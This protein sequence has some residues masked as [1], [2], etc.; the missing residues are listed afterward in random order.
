METYN[1]TATC[2][3]PYSKRCEDKTPMNLPKW[4]SLPADASPSL[5]KKLCPKPWRYQ[6]SEEMGNLEQIS[7][8]ASYGG[9]GYVADLGYDIQT[10]RRV[11]EDL[12]K[13]SWI[14]VRS[15]AAIVEF[16]IFNINTN[17][18][19][20][21]NYF[22]EFLPTGGVFSHVK[23]EILQLYGTE[24]SFA[25]LV[26]LFRLL[27]IVM[28]IVYLV[29][30][31]VKLFRQK[32]SYFRNI[33][34]WLS[35][36]LII[37]SVT[38][39]V[40][41]IVG[42]QTT[43][44]IIKE[45][46]KNIY[47]TASFHQ[48][49]HL[50]DIETVVLAVVIF[51][52]TVKLLSLLRFSK[53]IIFLS[54]TVRFAG[55]CL[56]SFSIIFIIIFL[57]FATCGM[58]AFGNTVDSY[59]SF[60]RVCVSQFEFLLGKAVPNFDMAKVDPFLAFLFSSLYICSMTIFFLNV[61]I[62][63]L[64]AALVEVKDNL[65]AVADKLDLA[66]FIVA[67]VTQGL[68]NMFRKRQ[69]NMHK[70][71]LYCENM[72][73]ED[74]CTY[75]ENCLGEIDRKVSI[76]AQ[77]ALSED[78]VRLMKA[79]LGVSSSIRKSVSS[80]APNKKDFYSMKVKPETSM[81]AMDDVA[82]VE[83]P[84]IYDEIDDG[85]PLE[86]PLSV[87]EIDYDAPLEESLNDDDLSCSYNFDNENTLDDISNPLYSMVVLTAMKKTDT[88]YVMENTQTTS[89]EVTMGRERVSRIVKS[90]ESGLGNKELFSEFEQN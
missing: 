26:L 66:D 79:R 45:L 19:V 87:E 46:Q 83:E 31:A 6:R 68:V 49:I 61:F 38:A 14:D 41:H 50:L 36:V 70:R 7:P 37:T 24:T 88:V 43:K 64:N 2:Y 65:D 67:Y 78:R 44:N 42:E 82:P 86:E 23:I 4:K 60:L 27:L 54:I 32:G 80:K 63:I 69:R 21:G 75:V 10:A 29:I 58:L 56:A 89:S 25:Q 81:S 40:L 13:N 15:R 35:I 34:N 74:E 85:A 76:L 22:F 53:Q 52:A 28:V 73:F 18:L 11:V 3:P 20:V 51:L 77:D 39:V 1:V 48:A 55:R 9:G 71:K 16:S 12:S 17:I 59:S 57:S 84:L 72:T 33:W 47:A 62:A 90:I 8:R 5:F 30:E